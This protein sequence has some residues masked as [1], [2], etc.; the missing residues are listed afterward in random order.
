MPKVRDLHSVN[1]LPDLTNSPAKEAIH[2]YNGDDYHGRARTVPRL[3]YAE[4]SPA[5]G[6]MQFSTAAYDRP[7][8]AK[9]FPYN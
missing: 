2:P 4:L 3:A 6:D 9:Q 7:K 5:G 8:Q 1:S